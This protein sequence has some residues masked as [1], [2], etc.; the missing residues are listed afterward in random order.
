MPLTAH[1]HSL[2]PEKST[3]W[4]AF[5]ELEA[6][7]SRAG[8]FLVVGPGAV[9][10]ADDVQAALRAGQAAVRY[11]K[12]VPSH[13]PPATVLEAT[14]RILAHESKKTGTPLEFGC[15]VLD[16]GEMWLLT[17][18]MVR[19]VPLSP[20][21]GIPLGVEKPMAVS[22]TE[23]DRFFLGRLPKGS[24]DERVSRDFQARLEHGG[25]G[26][27]GLVLQM[28]KTDALSAVAPPPAEVEERRDEGTFDA[29][30]KEL[31]QTLEFPPEEPAVPEPVMVSEEH[32]PAKTEAPGEQ[33]AETEPETAED[34]EAAGAEPESE[35]VTTPSE[36][37]VPRL[38]L[39]D[40][41]PLTKAPAAYAPEETRGLGF[42][43]GV[44][45]A[46]VTLGFLVVYLAVLRPRVREGQ[47][48]PVTD[49]VDDDA[50]ISLPPDNLAE[51]K[52]WDDR[53]TEAVTSSPLLVDDKVIFGCRDGRVYALSRSN[54]QRIWAYAASEGFG[55]SPSL[56]GSMVVIGGYDGKVYALDAITGEER[57]VV[58]TQGR[59]VASPAVNENTAY[60]GSYDHNLYAISVLDGRVLWTR[61][62]GSVIWASPVF[63]E[64]ALIATGLDGKVFSIDPG[65]GKVIWQAD[66]GGPIYSSPAVGG[67][68]VFVGSQ[69]GYLNAFDLA[70]GELVWKIEGGGEVNGSPG[71]FD[72]QVVVG[73]DS[74]NI[75][76]VEAETGKRTW[77]I[78]TDGEVKSR[79]AFV[80]RMVWV[81]GY[82]GYF[83]G[84]DWRTGEEVARIRTDS[85]AFSSPAI[86]D[87]IAYFGTMDGRFFAIRVVGTS[88]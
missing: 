79:P 54:G 23:D 88:S 74:G 71:Y 9:E 51:A 3:G 67:G 15:V 72:G 20:D 13:A 85:S 61:D 4:L 12:E 27:G 41:D 37:P 39:E 73:T 26:D 57:W 34:P 46:V 69:T 36:T 87:G 60:V 35:E 48:P 11:L 63:H 49:V 84:I 55:S 2:R 25:G 52:V 56:C 83:H 78:S 30:F 16:N 10:S 31:Q 44:T 24:K 32:I 50:A 6:K 86:Q 40:P 43:L 7:G 21:P 81:P 58:A 80:G 77:Q 19:L 8:S 64:G 17:R 82:D 22:V 18:G 68:R 1:C 45:A 66:T 33:P 76:G 28:V 29:V 5:F 47:E 75:I 59:I 14:S 70:G 38:V 62:L 65:S 53:F 42:W